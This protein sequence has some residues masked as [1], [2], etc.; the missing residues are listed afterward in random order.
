MFNYTDADDP[1]GHFKTSA[2]YPEDITDVLPKA[3]RHPFLDENR[4]KK[5]HL[6]SRAT[7][8]SNRSGYES[9]RQ[10]RVVFIRH[11]ATPR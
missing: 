2:S 10:I 6:L 5:A 11:A 9:V 7:Q 8:Q 4:N 1:V 3:T